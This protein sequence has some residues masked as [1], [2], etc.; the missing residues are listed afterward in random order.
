MGERLKEIVSYRDM[1]GRLVRRDLR[2]RYKGSVLGFLW[3]FLNPM[4]QIV[5]YIIVFSMIFPSGIENYYIY[6]IVGMMPWNFFAEAVKEGAG[7]VVNQ[8]DMAKKIYFPR[9]V[10]AI[11]AVT[12]RLVNFLITYLVVFGIILISGVGI[13]MKSLLVLPLV[14]VTEYIFALGLALLF[15]GIDVYFRDIEHIIGV[16]LMAWVWGTPVMY[17]IESAGT[18]V[19]SKVVSLNPMTWFVT[20]YHN[21]LYDQ[22]LPN[23]G[24]LFRCF[25]IAVVLLIIGETVFAKLEKNFAEEL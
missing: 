24:M 20:A 9:E 8:A 10:L 7:C 5:V 21:I 23:A 6:L 1:V 19:L 25:V 15:A 2:G 17:A 22:M 3:N 14:I 18:G 12:S 13:S 11:S 16:F 4:C